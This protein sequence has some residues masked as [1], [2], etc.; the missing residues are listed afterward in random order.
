MS[1]NQPVAESHWTDKTSENYIR[2]RQPYLDDVGIMLYESYRSCLFIESSTD[3]RISAQRELLCRNATG[4]FNL[5]W[6][7]YE[8]YETKCSEVDGIIATPTDE[9]FWR[10]DYS[11]SRLFWTEIKRTGPFPSN[12]TSSDCVSAP[13]DCDC[14]SKTFQGMNFPGD[15]YATPLMNLTKVSNMSYVFTLRNIRTNGKKASC[16]CVKRF[17]VSKFDFD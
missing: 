8:D 12:F 2:P 10:D 14:P 4:L 13:R 9:F 11:R 17:V 7:K 5:G 15:V 1:G 3:L 6:V 16:V